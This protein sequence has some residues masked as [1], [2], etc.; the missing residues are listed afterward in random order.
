MR[1]GDSAKATHL[2]AATPAPGVLCRLLW[3]VLTS[4]LGWG[5]LVA[6][7]SRQAVEREKLAKENEKKIAL[8]P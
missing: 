8:E 5:G 7:K 6:Q 2:R 3:S 4:R 1:Q